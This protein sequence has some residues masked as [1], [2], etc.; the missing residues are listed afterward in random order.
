MIQL[1]QRFRVQ[2]H[3]ALLVNWNC[4]DIFG[5]LTHTCRKYIA[6][7]RSLWAGYE[8]VRSLVASTSMISTYNYTLALHAEV[9]SL[10]FR[11]A[12]AKNCSFALL[13]FSTSILV[14]GPDGF[15]NVF[16]GDVAF[17]DC[18][19]LLLLSSDLRVFVVNTKL[20]LSYKAPSSIFRRHIWLFIA[21][22]R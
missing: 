18:G 12:V 6:C 16:H 17:K 14:G 4:V 13:S 15:I 10:L 21:A 5:I 3:A 1:Q 2:P 11:I 7:Q 8:I 22:V 9:R 19:I 20:L